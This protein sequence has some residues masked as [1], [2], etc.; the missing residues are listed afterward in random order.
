VSLLQLVIVAACVGSGLSA[1]MAAAW[2]VQQKTA[3]SGWVDVFWTLGTGGIALVAAVFPL[4]Q[5]SWPHWR[6]IVLAVLVAC[7]CLRLGLHIASRTRS[8]VDDPRYRNLIKQWGNNAPRQMFW[9]LQMQA[10]VGVVLALSVVLAAQNSDPDIRIQDL[11]GAAILMIG[12]IGE[13]IA[14]RQ[15]RAFKANSAN[16]NAVCDVGLW[17]WSRHPN[18][19][20]E[21]LSWVGYPLVAVDLSG[22][23]PFGWLAF[24]A[25]VCMYWVLVHVSGIPPLEEHM[26]RSRGDAFRAYQQ[27]T[28]PFFPLPSKL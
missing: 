18:Y 5:A 10:A 3:N 11:L 20:F 21:W 23:N 25:P 19:F 8:I 28:R 9:F 2:C 1:I 24:I 26:L 22:Y 4:G 15:L 16:R 17:R 6:Q 14:D 12:V 13:T 7:W 27:R